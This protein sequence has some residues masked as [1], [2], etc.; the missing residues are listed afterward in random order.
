ML[1]T[2]THS[3]MNEDFL[4]DCTAVLVR[5]PAVLDSLL[6]GVPE[7]WTEATEGAGTWSP[8]TVL[9]HLIHGEKTDWIPRMETILRDGT[10]RAFARFD[11][12]AQFP[13]SAGRSVAELLDE[14]AQRRAESM[15]RLRALCLDEAKLAAKGLHPDLGVVTARQLLATWTAHDLAHL[16]QISRVMA[17]RLRAEVGPWAEYLSVMR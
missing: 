17:K 1:A 5:T 12:E 15:G 9:G 13:E 7:A 3:T 11:R 10:A 4:A 2:M 6:R 8:R 14:F 16:L